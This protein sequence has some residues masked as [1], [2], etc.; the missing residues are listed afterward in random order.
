M[1]RKKLMD[2]LQVNDWRGLRSTKLFQSNA[3]KFAISNVLEVIF[4]IFDFVKLQ[5]S[6]GTHKVNCEVL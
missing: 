2:E 1:V 5:C 3:S 4:F 6:G